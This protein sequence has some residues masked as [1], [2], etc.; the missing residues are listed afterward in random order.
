MLSRFMNPREVGALP[1]SPHYNPAL[2]SSSEEPDPHGITSGKKLV[3]LA[4]TEKTLAIAVRNNK[5]KLRFM[6]PDREVGV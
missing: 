2:R 1:Y 3:A 6:Q 5:P 4:R